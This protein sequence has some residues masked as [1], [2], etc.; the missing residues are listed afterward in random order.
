MVVGPER[1]MPGHLNAKTILVM[2]MSVQQPER[3]RE[4]VEKMPEIIQDIFWQY[5][6]LQRTQAQIGKT[7]SMKQSLGWG[8][9]SEGISQLLKLGIEG[10]CA[11]IAWGGPPP[12]RDW[13]AQM[14]SQ[15]Q[16]LMASY[17]EVEKWR[18][19]KLGRLNIS[20]DR[21]LGKFKV[22]LGENGCENGWEK[23][24]AAKAPV[25]RESGC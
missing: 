16:R 1:G 2:N 6:I 22:K 9:G 15:E 5:C 11:M 14:S 8:A 25:A 13:V 17:W 12:E 3:F 7:L 18:G 19:R 23:H 20:A 4:L 21:E 24:F 10:M